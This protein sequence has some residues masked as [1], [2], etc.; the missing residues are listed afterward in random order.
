MEKYYQ[1][2]NVSK[3]GENPYLSMIMTSRNDDYGGNALERTQ[4][5]VSGRLEQLEKHRI[6]S[7][8]IL[9]EWNPPAD[10]PLL[11]DTI[12]WPGPLKYC[13]IRDIV[14]PEAIHRR[15]EHSDKTLMYVVMA[16]NCGIRRARGQY[17]LPGNIDLLYSDELMAYIGERNLKEDERYRI[18]RC[19]VDRNVV[20]CE[21]LKEQLNYCRS[22]IIN[23]N[24]KGPQLKRER[25]PHLHTNACGD[26]QL[27]SK[28]FWHLLRGYRE[29]DIPSAYADS[30]LSFASYAAGMHEVV[31]QNPLCLYHMDHE[32]KFNERPMSSGL[33][34]ENRL[35]FPFLPE[36]LNN[37]NIRV[38]R[39]ILTAFGYKLKGNENGIPTLHFSEY[40][41]IARDMVE[42]KRP[43]VF[44]NENW[45]LGQ[46]TLEEYVVNVA[47]WDKDYEK[48]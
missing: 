19:D 11:K 16:L 36:K 2:N 18:D 28:R 24:T 44:N 43:Y 6:E 8:F 39:I 41:K 26:F 29:S 5:S 25:L 15:Y 12:R 22:N 30:L 45:G 31:F 10:R 47:E 3:P 4:V 21:T 13:T 33:P 42:G 9:V 46:D 23:T 40:R 32:G 7:E 38:C 35:K 17:V 37:F 34:F 20:K 27:M 14:V 1:E 48:N